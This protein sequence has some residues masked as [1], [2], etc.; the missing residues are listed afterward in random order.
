[1]E[2]FTTPD[3]WERYKALPKAVQELADKNYALLRADTSH[4]SLHSKK[5][6]EVWSV[7]VGLHYRALAV[8]REDRGYTNITI[9]QD[10]KDNSSVGLLSLGKDGRPKTKEF[11][12][13]P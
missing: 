4:P 11:N 13:K 8:E 3:F 10:N 12:L 5:I 7:R 9:G 6:G 2:N 1:M